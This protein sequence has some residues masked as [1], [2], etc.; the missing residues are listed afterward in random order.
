MLISLYTS[1]VILDSLGVED[2]GIYNA[3]GG[4]VSMFS[5][6]RAGLV[7]ATQRFITYD[8]GKGDLNELN[9]TFSTCVLIYL[10]L[11]VLIVFIGELLGGWFIENKMTIPEL[12]LDAAKIVYHLSLLLLVIG[13]ISNPYHA[14]VIAH[15][16]MSVFAYITIYEALAK[17]GIS[18]LIYVA[19][20][21]KLVVYALLLCL[22]QL[23]V[24]LMY[25]FYCH[26]HFPESKISWLFDWRKIKE[27][28]SFTGWA[29]F[30]GL[31]H[32]GFTQGLNI[33]LNIFFNPTVNAARAIAV[34]VQAAVSHFVTSFQS[35]VNPQIIKSYSRGDK[36]YMFSLIYASSKFS[37]FL[38]FLIS[39]P[40]VIEA[41]QIL[42]LWLKEVPEY[43]AVF[44]R[45][46]VVT[47]IID[48]VSN[49]IMRAVDATGNIR[50][51]QSIVGGLLLLIVPIS[52]I[53]LRL[54]GAPY[55]VFVVHIVMGILA[56]IAR[57]YLASGIVGI[58]I[59]VFCG[60]VLLR[61][62]LLMLLS[63]ILPLFI[64]F[65][66]DESLA[67]LTLICITSWVAIILLAYSV[68]LSDGER[69]FLN[70]KVLQFKRKIQGYDN[71]PK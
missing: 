11:S 59:K 14:L 27:I 38:I 1:R 41:D 35:A 20:F 67:R 56:F 44:F 34:Q 63:V 18:Y 70:A 39:L 3:V 62:M 26:R 32:M 55:T 48:A 7:S 21:D 69:N 71:C 47:T 43:S 6:F 31:A 58:S 12:R 22:V 2:Y 28:Y 24:R 40:L 50:K 23:S 54:G 61:I 52:Y 15:E 10:M 64:Y 46:I 5:V 13:L 42:S 65:Q 60:N 29:M 51:Y 68:G 36:E 19:A 8:L 66:M 53:V 37:F 9:H 4:F 17:L 30:G 16:K 49:P 45:L 57:L 25:S 33:L